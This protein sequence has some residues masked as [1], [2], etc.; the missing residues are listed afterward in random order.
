M[1][2][3]ILF[4]YPYAVSV[5]SWLHD[6]EESVSVN[7]TIWSTTALSTVIYLTFGKH[8][9]I[10]VYSYRNPLYILFPLA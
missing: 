5:P 9:Y 6:K 1:C 7:K 8:V 10:C 3:V 2:G 4:N